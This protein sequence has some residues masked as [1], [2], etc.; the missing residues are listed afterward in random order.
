MLDVESGALHSV[1][2]MTYDIVRAIED[3]KDPRDLP[4]AAS[5]IDEALFELSELKEA[6][7][8]DSEGISVNSGEFGKGVI[9]SLCL[10]IAHD[11]NLRCKYCFADTGEF[12]GSRG[13]MSEEVGRRALEF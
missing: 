5:D 9:K 11:C 6:G 8:F 3:G 1:D 13:L 7:A 2:E 10:H 4:Y 12:H